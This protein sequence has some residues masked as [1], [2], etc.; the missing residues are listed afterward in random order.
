M[1]QAG[2]LAQQIVLLTLTAVLTG[3]N[4]RNPNEIKTKKKNTS[5]EI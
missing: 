3:I 2:T 1:T 4:M 5:T